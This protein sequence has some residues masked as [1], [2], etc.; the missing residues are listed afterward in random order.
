M[1]KPITYSIECG[2]CK[3]P[4]RFSDEDAVK[5]WKEKHTIYCRG[6]RKET[7]YEPS[8]RKGKYKNEIKKSN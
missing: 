1:T 5:R 7:V 2:T 3:K 8:V 6:C 4:V